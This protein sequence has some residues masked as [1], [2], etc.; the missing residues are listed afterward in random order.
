MDDLID[1]IGL[2]SDRE[3]QRF[4]QFQ[5]ARNQ[6]SD[7]KNTA[8]FRLLCKKNYTHLDTAIYGKPA[9]NNLYAL[10][11]RLKD[12][13]IEFIAI[14]NFEEES[15]EE[16]HILR[17]LLAARVFF[18]QRLF[19]LAMKTLRKAEQEAEMLD[20][21]ALLCEIYHT[22]VQH[23][24]HYP[25]E[26]RSNAITTYHK[27]V[28]AL[29]QEHQINMLCAQV[30]MASEA[31]QTAPFSWLR[32]DSQLQFDET[33]TYKG[34]FMVLKQVYRVGEQ[35]RHFKEA[36]LWITRLFSAVQ[37]KNES[38]T[39]HRYYYSRIL[40]LVAI[41]HFRN[42]TFET[43]LAV[44]S[45]L[46]EALNSKLFPGSQ[47]LKQQLQRYRTLNFLYSGDLEKAV[48]TLAELDKTAPEA[49]LIQVLVSFQ[50]EHFDAAYR[51]LLQL[52]RSPAYYLKTFG[53]AWVL[54][55]ELMEILL[56]MEKDLLDPLASR[57]KSF[58]RK[59]R[60]TLQRMGESRALVFL[61]LAEQWYDTPS[62]ATSE[63]FLQKIETSF[64]WRSLEE[65]DLFAM[66]FYAW[67]K[68]KTLQQPI[69]QTTLEVLRG[70][71]TL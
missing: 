39:K 21:Y 20:A 59:Y 18:E 56:L 44:L 23:L 37:G 57:L 3:R 53:N 8:L 52:D 55:K 10:T 19:S 49:I 47:N 42:K 58:R 14:Q 15:S 41:S 45:Q 66:S 65:E 28:R 12:S 1:I 68:S 38:T 27:Y 7:T 46:E 16:M 4:I 30:G 48:T 25:S 51:K 40:L 50:Q 24:H 67:L 5:Q 71:A 6:R 26:T 63:E 33:I 61:S 29:Q 64:E 43:S 2:L 35:T 34:Y 54:Q 22:K 36:H 69:Y 13:L 70:D 11:K 32:T 9:K 17:G 62:V 60:T 31:P